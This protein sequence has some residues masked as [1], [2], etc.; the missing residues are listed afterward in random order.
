MAAISSALTFLGSN[1]QQFK[2]SCFWLFKAHVSLYHGSSSIRI[3]FYKGHLIRATLLTSLERTYNLGPSLVS[4]IEGISYPCHRTQVMN[5][6]FHSKTF[7]SILHCLPK[8]RKSRYYT[9]TKD[10]ML[11][12]KLHLNPWT[13]T[14]NWSNI[15]QMSQ[16]LAKVMG[17]TMKWILMHSTQK[18]CHWFKEMSVSANYGD[19]VSS[20]DAAMIQNWRTCRK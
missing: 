7:L 17:Y 18:I 3:L 8:L 14:W 16:N 9:G 20:H 10:G 1:I 19:V 15:M 12:C 2:A 11:L 5:N 6:L 13:E 4:T